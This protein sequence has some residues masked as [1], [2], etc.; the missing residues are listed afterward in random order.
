MV[1]KQDETLEKLEKF[2]GIKMAKIPMRKDPVGRWKN[3]EGRHMF[4]FFE[5]DLIECGYV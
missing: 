5:E 1:F 4:D 3:D 2:L